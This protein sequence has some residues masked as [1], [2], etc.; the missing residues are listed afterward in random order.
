MN[1]HTCSAWESQ[2]GGGQAACEDLLRRLIVQVGWWEE[3]QGEWPHMQCVEESGRGGAAC[4]DLLRRVNCP[5]GGIHLGNP[6]FE[7]QN[8][9]GPPSF[10]HPFPPSPMQSHT[11]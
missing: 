5:G 3:S 1:G 6:C 4:E 10:L 2:G 11:T 9:C 7:L 8:K